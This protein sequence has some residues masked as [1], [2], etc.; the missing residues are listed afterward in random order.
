MDKVQRRI[1]H[2]I[3][4]NELEDGL[5][6]ERLLEALKHHLTNGR[7]TLKMNDFFNCGIDMGIVHL[8][9][10]PTDLR[11]FFKMHGGTKN[12][13]DYINEM[14][15]LSLEEIVDMANNDKSIQ[16]IYAVSPLLN[17][18]KIREKFE[19]FGFKTSKCNIKELKE[20]FGDEDLFQESIPIEV[21]RKFV[22][23]ERNLRNSVKGAL[24]D[25][26]TPQDLKYDRG[27]IISLQDKY[28][29]LK[30]RHENMNGSLW[31][32]MCKNV[33]EAIIYKL[34]KKRETERETYDR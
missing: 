5:N 11:P 15:F 24:S 3:V 12:T 16:Y 8:H 13:I 32:T 4:S 27:F 9:V 34:S 23:A 2:N 6:E 33:K 7:Q 21:A 30:E 20:R 19:M 31:E 22:D 29:L 14:M 18:N 1:N 10:T 17:D 28:D 25:G 26:K